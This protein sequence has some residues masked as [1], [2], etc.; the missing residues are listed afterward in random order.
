MVDY[1]EEWA[2]TLP[3][4]YDLIIGVPRGGLLV[5][6][7][8]SSKFNKPLTTPENFLNGKNF[9]FSKDCKTLDASNFKTALIV[10]DSIGSGKR[11]KPYIEKIKAKNPNL[12]IKVGALFKN[13]NS[14][15]PIDVF[16][17]EKFPPII[18]EWNLLTACHAWGALCVDMDGVLCKEC[19]SEFDDDG[20]KYRQWLRSVK[21]HLIPAYR[22][23]AVIT[24]RLE[25]YRTETE[26]WLKAN[27]VN[28]GQLIMLDLPSK[29]LRT[30]EAIVKHK[31]DAINK[32]KPFWYWESSANEAKEIR[33]LVK[34]H[35]LCMDGLYII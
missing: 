1:T 29:E 27:D 18:F 14:V 33:L 17:K 35:I 16:Y 15:Y 21:P 5:A 20:E 3:N 6:G 13:H 34:C 25:K 9:W 10:E 4:E 2:Q 11:L 28:Y 30:F 32:I 23:E 22:I 19:P 24:S 12:D 26:A 8:L 7:I 31:S